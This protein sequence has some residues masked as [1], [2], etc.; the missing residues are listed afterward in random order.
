MFLA[1]PCHQAATQQLLL[2]SLLCRESPLLV[3]SSSASKPPSGRYA[4]DR[5]QNRSLYKNR[6]PIEIIYKP[7]TSTNVPIYLFATKGITLLF[8]MR[9]IKQS[10]QKSCSGLSLYPLFSPIKMVTRTRINPTIM[11]AFPIVV[12]N[13]LTQSDVKI[14]PRGP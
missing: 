4:R 12:S 13:C 1:L 9:S 10:Y 7:I 5:R 3:I 14:L 8:N 11:L 2:P 6:D